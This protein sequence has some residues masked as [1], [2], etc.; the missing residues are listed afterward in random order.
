MIFTFDLDVS[1][2]PRVYTVCCL[3]VLELFL[4]F[5]V[6]VF[7]SPEGAW[8]DAERRAEGNAQCGVHP[9]GAA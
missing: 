3:S 4:A 6:F 5:S 8:E 9:V 7:T 1:T 2:I